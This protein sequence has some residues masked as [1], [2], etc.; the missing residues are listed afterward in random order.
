MIILSG[1]MVATLLFTAQVGYRWITVG[2]DGVP[3]E[4]QRYRRVH[5]GRCGRACGEGRVRPSAVPIPQWVTE[6]HH[7]VVLAL[8]QPPP[9]SRS[10]W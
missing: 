8:A 7:A 1:G 4:Q 10:R 5:Y 9:P 6:A 2:M 3:A